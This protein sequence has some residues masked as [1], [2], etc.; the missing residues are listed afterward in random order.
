[1]YTKVTLGFFLLIQQK[2]EKRIRKKPYQKQEL[3]NV[4]KFLGTKNWFYYRKKKDKK[5]NETQKKET[6]KKRKW[7]VNCMKII[8]SSFP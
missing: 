5:K 2:Q 4:I 6:I 1:M 3:I 7:Y 8:V